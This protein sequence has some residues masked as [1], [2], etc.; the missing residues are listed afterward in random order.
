MADAAEYGL[1]LWD[2]KS[3]GTVNNVVKLSRDNKPVIVYIAPT[4][5]FRTI[6][7]ATTCCRPNMYPSNAHLRSE[8]FR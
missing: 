1:M 3:K 6:S 4:R 8:G 7:S 2:G 5:Q